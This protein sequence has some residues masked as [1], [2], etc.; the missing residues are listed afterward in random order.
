MTIKSNLT[1]LLDLNLFAHILIKIFIFYQKKKKKFGRSQ[2]NNTHYY[3]INAEDNQ[4]K[5]ICF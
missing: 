5:Y 4:K 3:F 1:K 2:T